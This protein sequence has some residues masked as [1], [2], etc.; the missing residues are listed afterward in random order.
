MSGH[1]PKPQ[2]DACIFVKRFAVAND[3]GVYVGS[4]S[5]YHAHVTQ[6][7][8]WLSKRLSIP[9]EAIRAREIIERGWVIR[10]HALK[11]VFREPST[12]DLDAVCLCDITLLGFYRR[13]NLQ[14]LSEAIDVALADAGLGRV[15]APDAE[16]A[17][18]PR[19]TLFGA[20]RR[21]AGDLLRPTDTLEIEI[22]EEAAKAAGIE[23]EGPFPS[24]VEARLSLLAAAKGKGQEALVDGI[25]AVKGRVILVKRICGLWVIAW[26][27]VLPGAVL[28]IWLVPRP[29][30]E[31]TPLT[32]AITAGICVLGYLFLV[33]FSLLIQGLLLKPF[34]ALM[35]WLLRVRPKEQ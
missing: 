3:K 17:V 8:L 23:F 29:P 7:Q 30:E 28:A 9:L 35:N 34:T 16:L 19:L 32:I 11:I 18:Q 2:R 20:I 31:W 14:K 10:R 12:G 5:R 21:A 15:A 6:D 13:K 24:A 26:A 27:V 33:P 1:S 22:Y 4:F 25:D